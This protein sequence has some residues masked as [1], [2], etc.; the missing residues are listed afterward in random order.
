M[1]VL[2]THLRM[3]EAVLLALPFWPSWRPYFRLLDG[4]LLIADGIDHPRILT[5]VGL[6]FHRFFPRWHI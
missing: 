2:P 4:F 1:L 6:P 5:Q 3:F